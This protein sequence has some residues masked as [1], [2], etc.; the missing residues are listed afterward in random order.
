MKNKGVV[1]TII[2]LSIAE[3]LLIDYASQTILEVIAVCGVAVCGVFLFCVFMT[4]IFCHSKL[5]GDKR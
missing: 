4:A 1:V 5:Q 3:I 2:G